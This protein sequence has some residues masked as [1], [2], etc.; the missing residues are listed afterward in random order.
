MWMQAGF[1]LVVLIY[2]IS[3]LIIGQ[4]YPSERPYSPSVNY[5]L[6]TFIIGL[7]FP[8]PVYALL[9]DSSDNRR[10]DSHTTTNVFKEENPQS[11]TNLRDL[12]NS[13]QHEEKL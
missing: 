12:P 2:S 1:C 3:S 6:I 9:T 7:W 4:V 11:L 13:N 5:N 8:S 10:G